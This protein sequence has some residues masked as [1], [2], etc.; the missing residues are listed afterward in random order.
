MVKKPIEAP[1]TLTKIF[2]NF[3]RFFSANAGIVLSDKALMAD[4]NF[5]Y[6]TSQGLWHC[7]KVRNPTSALSERISN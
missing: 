1:T 2:R 4:F 5:P 6:S 3:P 7:T